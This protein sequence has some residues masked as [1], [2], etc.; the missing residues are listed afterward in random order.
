MKSAVYP[1]S[2]DPITFGHL[3]VIKRASEIFDLVYVAV[4][5]NPAKKTMF[6]SEERLE[7]IKEVTAPLKNVKVENFSGL[8]IN[9]LREKKAKIIIRGLRAVTDFDY[10]FALAIMNR[11]LATEIETIFMMP[12]EKYSFLSSTLVK[13]VAV[14]GGNIECYVPDIVL[15][16]IKEKLHS[17]V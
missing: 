10:E 8:L 13:E 15:K 6:S 17:N 1:G 14:L 2:F 11:K 3:D 5:N 4:A 16:K 7:I 9:Y 12:N